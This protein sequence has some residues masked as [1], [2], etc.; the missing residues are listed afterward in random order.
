MRELSEF[1]KA[2][3][4]DSIPETDLVM[5]CPGLQGR[6]GKLLDRSVNAGH[7]TITGASWAGTPRGLTCLSFDGIAN[8]VTMAAGLKVLPATGKITVAAWV[9]P[10]TTVGNIDALSRNYYAAGGFG[11]RTSQNNGQFKPVLYAGGATRQLGNAGAV[12]ALTWTFLAFSY[13]LNDM[14]EYI[15]GALTLAGGGAWGA[16]AN[17][18]N[19]ITLA[20]NADTAYYPGKV[21][22]SMIWGRV[23]TVTELLRL[24]T[25]QRHIFGV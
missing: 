15:N 18:N 17:P 25:R 13:E 8:K 20:L 9:N 5:F 23:L 3:I 16:L 10:A 6:G 12:P 11:L 14:K 2:E 7:G 19:D 1:D 4:I 24:Y 22:M 21:A